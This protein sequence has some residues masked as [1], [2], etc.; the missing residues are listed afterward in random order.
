MFGWGQDY[1]PEDMLKAF[2]AIAVNA[3]GTPVTISVNKY[4]NNDAANYKSPDKGG[5]QDALKVKDALMS[6]GMKDVLARAGGPNAYVG[7][8]VGKGSPEAIGAVMETLVDYSER[9]IERYKKSSGV[10]KKVADWLADENLSWQATLQNVCDE[11]V[12]LDCNGFVGNWVR[13]RDNTSK[14]GPNT[15]PRDVFDMRKKTKRR[16][17]DDIQPKDVIVWANYSHIAAV[18]W[19][20]TSEAPKF[21]ICQSAGGGPR[22]NEYLL[23]LSSDGA[24]T[25]QRPD[26]KGDVGGAVHIISLDD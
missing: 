23:R 7:V 10:L 17:I 19:R 2:K 9:Y 18:D 4:R 6:L 15:R 5:T 12:G 3:A 16:K 13:H 1:Y 14:I 11:V 24:F 21:N 20:P 22:L 25:L 26:P 8:F